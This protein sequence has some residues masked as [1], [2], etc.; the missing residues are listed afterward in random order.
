MLAV[1]EKEKLRV[2]CGDGR[3]TQHRFCNTSVKGRNI[4]ETQ[5]EGL[6]TKNLFSNVPKHQGQNGQGKTKELLQTEGP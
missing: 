6:S 1:L 5:V 3:R 2:A 4:E